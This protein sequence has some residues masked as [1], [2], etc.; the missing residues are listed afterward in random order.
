MT[1]RSRDQGA[2][3]GGP[4]GDLAPRLPDLS[5]PHLVSVGLRARLVRCAARVVGESEAEDVVQEALLQARAAHSAAHAAGREGASIGPGWLYAVTQR[6]AIDRV[7]RRER[8]GRALT[9]ASAGEQATA[10]SAAELAERRDE[11]RKLASALGEVP[12]P[13]ATALRLRYLE[14]LSFSELA[15]QTHTLERTARGRVARGLAKLREVMLAR[16]SDT[17]DGRR[18]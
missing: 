17:P 3:E 10:P 11:L 8:R 2:K 6:R 5:E 15:A 4:P 9:A 13:F 14:G 16:A 7:R 1:G 12:E 18:A